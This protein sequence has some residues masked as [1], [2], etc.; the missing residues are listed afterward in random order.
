MEGHNRTRGIL[1]RP[2][3]K[4]VKTRRG[5]GTTE[6]FINKTA[7]VEGTGEREELVRR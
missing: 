5:T 1:E 3:Y 4:E 6:K 2:L 7:L